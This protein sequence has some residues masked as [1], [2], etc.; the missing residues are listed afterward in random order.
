MKFVGSLQSIEAGAVQYSTVRCGEA[1]KSKYINNTWVG[2]DG[3]DL[4]E[5]NHNVFDI[6][7]N[8]LGCRALPSIS[9]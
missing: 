3:Y 9:S 1:R 5:V 4:S 8:I 6:K 2:Y 7:I